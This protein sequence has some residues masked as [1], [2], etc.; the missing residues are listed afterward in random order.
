MRVFQHKRRD[1]AGKVRRS[2]T[3]TLEFKVGEIRHRFPGFS[4]KA[5]TEELGRTI[6]RLLAHHKLGRS[7]DRDPDLAGEVEGLAPEVRERLIEVGLV[8]RERFAG[9]KPLAEHLEDFRASLAARGNTPAH[10]HTTVKRAAQVFKGTN[11][12]YWQDIDAL[13]IERYLHELREHGDA[14]LETAKGNKRKAKPVWSTTSNYYLRDARTFCTWMVNAGRATENPLRVLRPVKAVPKYDRLPLTPEESQKLIACTMASGIERYGALAI[15]R[16]W[17]YRLG[18]EIGSRPNKEARNLRVGDLT[19]EGAELTATLEAAY[20]KAKR[21]DT[22][23]LK[24]ST[25]R[26]LA[27]FLGPRGRFPDARVFPNFPSKYKLAKMLREDAAAAGIEIPKDPR[28]RLD[29]YSGTR[30]TFVTNLNGANV[31]VGTMQRL[32]R[33][34]D[35]ATTLKH[36]VRVRGTDRARAIESLPDLGTPAPKPESVRR[37]GTDAT[38]THRNLHLRPGDTGGQAATEGDAGAIVEG[39]EPAP[40]WRNWQTRWTQ[41]PAPPNAG[42]PESSGDSHD[43][44]SAPEPRTDPCTDPDLDLARVVAAWPS[45]SQPIRNAL[46]ALI[47]ARP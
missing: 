21:E 28:V 33:H 36:Y 19:L 12:T 8:D 16:A 23:P 37:T 3:W 26:E 9:V 45:L 2:R 44:G 39:S 43:S 32:A 18:S 35:S 20:T 47:E 13:A 41:N 5:A 27:A 10:V 30:T 31:D 1:A 25:A 40:G 22:I 17:I 4:D 29:F 24:A 42:Q 34:R 7:L 6:D 46:L 15:E 14:N 38:D 11:A